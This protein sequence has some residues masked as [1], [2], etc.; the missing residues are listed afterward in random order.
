MY[1]ITCSG[2]CSNSR[3]ES[4]K[5]SFFFRHEAIVF[6][7]F[8]ELARL[9]LKALGDLASLVREGVFVIRLGRN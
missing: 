5:D 3:G 6:E 4:K 1:G 8:L 7:I 2:P 9:K